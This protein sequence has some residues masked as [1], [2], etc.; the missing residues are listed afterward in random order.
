MAT[1]H[2]VLT[3]GTS[4]IQLTG[5]PVSSTQQQALLVAPDSGVTV[6]VGGSAVSTS[7]YG[8]AVTYPSTASFDIDG[9]LYGICGSAAQTVR[10][11][12]SGVQ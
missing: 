3:I 11:I 8:V 10:V 4:A 6:Y 9:P 7:D 1:R 2:A 12:R 5:E